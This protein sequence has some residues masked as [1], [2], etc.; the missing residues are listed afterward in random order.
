MTYRERYNEAFD[1]FFVLKHSV[2][3]I[4]VWASLPLAHIILNFQL[5]NKTNSVN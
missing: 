1:F 2:G 5:R 4:S 3:D